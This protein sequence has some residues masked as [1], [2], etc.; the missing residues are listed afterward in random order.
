MFCGVFQHHASF[1]GDLASKFVQNAQF[2]H[3]SGGLNCVYFPGVSATAEERA[4]KR[5]KRYLACWLAGWA[6]WLAGWSAS[7]SSLFRGSAQI[8]THPL[9]LSIK[10]VFSAF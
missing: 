2:G 7:S 6:G 3:I 9:E 8:P 1:F 10:H 4:L 5:A